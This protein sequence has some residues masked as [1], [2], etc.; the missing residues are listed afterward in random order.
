MDPANNISTIA[1][2]TTCT[3][4][5]D[6]SNYWTAV[7]YF[8]ARNGTFKR[9]PQ[10]GNELF[11][12]ANGGMTVYYSPYTAKGVKTTAFKQVRIIA[13]GVG[14]IYGIGGLGLTKYKGI[15][16]A[17]WRPDGSNCS[18]SSEIPPTYIYLSANPRDKNQ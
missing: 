6:F 16:Y 2:C 8:R 13:T 9:V 4:S 3:F 18:W 10:I 14:D 17:R 11:E 1:T 15:P 5:E 12:S 7:L